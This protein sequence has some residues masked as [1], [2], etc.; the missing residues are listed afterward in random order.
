MTNQET[1]QAAADFWTEANN[2]FVASAATLTD[3]AQRAF[4]NTRE[5]NQ[6][7]VSRFV[8]NAVRTSKEFAGIR[9]PHAFVDKQMA[10]AQEAGQQFRAVAHAYAA[11]VEDTRSAYAAWAQDAAKS[12]TARVEKVV[13]RVA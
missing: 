9:D 6:R 5:Q 11:L 7:V 13:A 3:I 12:A 1:L 8:D 4:E 2:E 10:V